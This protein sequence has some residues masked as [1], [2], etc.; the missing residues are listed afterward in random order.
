MIQHQL[1]RARVTV[2]AAPI[3]MDALGRVG[4]ALSD[5]SRRRIL[6]ALLDGPAFP[7]ELAR[8]LDLTRAN[9]SNHLT[10]LRGCSL[11][12]AT[13][14]GRRVRYELAHPRLAHAL[15][16]LVGLVLAPSDPSYAVS[17]V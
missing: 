2:T 5:A 4:K 7:A 3:D 11:V 9:V 16:D 15:R 17:D 1:Y 12:T 13:P 6:V 10:C 14:A 8:D